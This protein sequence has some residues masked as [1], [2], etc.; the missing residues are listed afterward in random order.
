M[1]AYRHLGEAEPCHDPVEHE[2][3]A[4]R[5]RRRGPGD[6]GTYI[7]PMLIQAAWSAIRVW[8]RQQARYSR[9]ARRFGEPKNPA[10]KKKAITAIAHTLL[11]IAYQVLKTGTLCRDLGADFYTRRNSPE[12][13]HKYLERELQKLYPGC[14]IT[15][16]NHHHQP[17]GGR[18]TTGRLT[19]SSAS[20]LGA[21]ADPGTPAHP[22]DKPAPSHSPA[23]A[24]GS[25][26][27][28]QTHICGTQV[29][30]RHGVTHC[31]CRARER[32]R[33]S[34]WSGPFDGGVI[35]PVLG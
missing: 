7:K 4:R 3:S 18:L 19:S 25:R 14:T 13:Q 10:A 29:A 35:L 5:S 11:K 12:E 31:L 34:N 21:A 9:L 20:Q 16:D 33:L 8:G 27:P 15:V 30:L 6:A 17:A 2:R 23:A 24:S 32:L 22:P 26:H 1:L 28:C